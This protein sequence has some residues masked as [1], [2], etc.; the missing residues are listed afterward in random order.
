MTVHSILPGFASSEAHVA[1]EL[2]RGTLLLRALLAQHAAELPADADPTRWGLS[3]VTPREVAAFI[4]GAPST[5]QPLRAC[6]AARPFLEEAARH[7]A[8]ID[9]TLAETGV[10]LR[11]ERLVGRLGLDARSRDALILLALAERDESCR[12]MIAYLHDNGAR[13]WF[14]AALLARA[15]PDGDASVLLPGAPLAD[16]RLLRE[17]GGEPGIMPTRLRLDWRVE[18]Y[19]AGRDPVPPELSETM[20]DPAGWDLPEAALD[21]AVLRQVEA[22]RRAATLGDAGPLVLEGRDGAGRA[23]LAL[24]AV[25]RHGG[26]ALLLDA[27][28]PA[29]VQDPVEWLRI[30]C[31]EAVLGEA[32]LVLVRADGLLADAATR[33]AMAA[34]FDRL[35]FPDAFP[36]ALLV[37]QGPT[38]ATRRPALRLTL[39]EARGDEAVAR[40][41]AVLTAS[42]QGENAAL[43]DLG[44]A[45]ALGPRQ[46]GEALRKAACLAQLDGRP[47]LGRREVER[48]CR[49]VLAGTLTRFGRR[50]APEGEADFDALVLPPRQ[51]AQI[52]EI[53]HRMRHGR[54]VLD[55]IGGATGTRRGRGFTVLFSGPSGAG[56]TMAAE[57]LALDHGVE[58]Y[59]VNLAE[60]VSKWVGETEK[61]LSALFHEARLLGAALFFDEADALF[62]K[63]GEV[64]EARD[65]WANLE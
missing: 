7:R 47:A 34:L 14:S 58:L 46:M 49:D 54:A 12:R 43:Q 11:L 27:G 8:W 65:R 3:E 10:T 13:P 30:A 55:R 64:K 28:C 15:L 39:R 44:I 36:V 9:A 60:V 21:A 32:T 50:L 23:A 24:A 33:H 56:K 29:A 52:A 22:W 5:E 25:E 62:G 17:P 41:R 19:L 31:R 18:R 53:R 26:R 42:G 45:V 1:A 4:E 59:S 16:W 40:W 61:H 35:L 38:P 57:L 51:S 20:L 48:A 37:N 63:R 6:P 2:A